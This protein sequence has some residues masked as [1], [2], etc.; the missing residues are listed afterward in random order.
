[1]NQLIN[2]PVNSDY[3][4]DV[5][6]LVAVLWRHRFIMTVVAVG[7]TVVGLL[8][9][10][11]QP[12]YYKASATV[13]INDNQPKI[14][15]FNDVTESPKFTDFTVQTEVRVL[16]SSSLAMETIKAT[17]LDKEKEYQ[18]IADDTRAILTMFEGNLAVAPQGSSR[19]IEVSFRAKDPDL[20]AKIA[21]AHVKAYLASQ[22]SRKNQRVVD[23]RNW[24]ETKVKELK[25]D[26]VTKSEAVSRLRAESNLP[27]D[28]LLDMIDAP[29][30]KDLKI[31]ESEISSRLKGLESKYGP[32]HPQVQEARNSLNSVRRSITFEVDTLVGPQ[33]TTD[34]FSESAS[35]AAPPVRL[36]E[37]ALSSPAPA[38]IP[39]AALNDDNLAD[40]TSGSNNDIQVKVVELKGLVLEQQASQKLLD[41]FMANYENIQSQDSF[42][43]P[44]AIISSEA[45]APIFPAPPGKKTLAILVLVAAG[46]ASLAT[47]ILIELLRGGI[48]NF[49]DIRRLNMKP[50]GVV[51]ETSDP[52]QMVL[53]PMNSS[54]KEAIK[55]IYMTGLMN[56]NVQSILVTSAMPQEG[57]TT[58]SRLFAYYLMSMGKKVLLIDADFLKPD[59]GHIRPDL[60]EKGLTD[61]L[62]GQLSISDAIQ[63]DSHGLYVLKTG[64]QTDALPELLKEDNV[65]NLLNALK[66]EYAQIIIDSA[67]I[68]ARNEANIFAHYVDGIVVV[69]KWG[70]TSERNIANMV[71]LLDSVKQKVLGVVINRIDIQKYKNVTTGADFLLPRIGAKD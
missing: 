26:V 67:P 40:V 54:F 11:M 23:L 32:R 64:T 15:D 28:A 9:I 43:R 31:R 35:K 68:L 36:S 39:E 46:I 60:S 58:F 16:T 55:Q 3:N 4:P 30:M 44:D 59:L 20:A 29:Y 57:R 27:A 1:M 18:A 7:I 45:L 62:S 12:T 6:D 25:Q 70:K 66:K 71:K 65:N 24:F 8:F 17:G 2:A 42:A 10:A 56:T 37:D 13:I 61:V 22:I 63:M 50:L 38:P 52:L 21:N 34:D 19:V 48:Q 14:T 53:S 47:A 49:D 69:S 41:S 33:Q 5:R 51:P